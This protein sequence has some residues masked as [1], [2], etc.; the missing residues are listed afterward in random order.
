MFVDAAAVVAILTREL[1][2]D[3]LADVLD[4]ALSPITSPIAIF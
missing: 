2:A 3:A 4:N 1:E